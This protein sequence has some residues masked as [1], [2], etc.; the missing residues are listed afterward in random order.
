MMFMLAVL[1]GGLVGLACAAV[2]GPVFLL[3]RVLIFF[4]LAPFRSIDNLTTVGY[5]SLVFTSMLWT[6][7]GAGILVLLSGAVQSIEGLPTLGIGL[8]LAI[9]AFGT[10]FSLEQLIPDPGHSTWLRR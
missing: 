8:G 3:I 2:I 7:G 1:V 6:C 4:P 5:L 10:W 9:G